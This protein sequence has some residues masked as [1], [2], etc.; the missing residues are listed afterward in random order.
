MNH[1]SALLLCLAL[2]ACDKPANDAATSGPALNSFP[3]PVPS[4]QA[5][6]P[7]DDVV[8]SWQGGQYTWGDLMADVK[9]QLIKQEID[10]LTKR[11]QI[12]RKA[13]DAKVA[14]SL[15]DAE[16][17][18]QGL[19][20]ADALVEKLNTENAE[21]S[22]KEVESFYEENKSRFRGKPL[23]AVKDQVEGRLKQSKQREAVGKLLEDLKEKA[24]VQVAIEAPELPRLEVSVDDDEPRGPAD[25][26]ITIVEFADYEC[27]YCKRGY[28]V[29]SKVMDEYEGKVRWVFRDYPLSFHK[30]A[31]SYAVAANCAGAQGKFWEMHDAILDN[32]KAIKKDGIEGQAEKLGLE[33]GAWKTCTKDEAQKKEVMADMTDGAALGVTGTPAFFI[34]GIMISGAQPF[35]NFKDI[36]DRELEQGAAK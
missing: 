19:A 11:Y 2:A 24:E 25:A 31:I 9:G 30:N 10:Y 23:E 21:V 28:D 5:D 36:I 20:D 34:N 1:P 13:I 27:P 29:M 22:E 26:P 35:E 7:P 32:Q 8:A 15:L 3:M 33:M 18:R 16:A 17:K 6:K 4:A 12:M 14:E